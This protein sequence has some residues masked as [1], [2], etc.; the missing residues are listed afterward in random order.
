MK[1]NRYF[2][3]ILIST[4]FITLFVTSCGPSEVVSEPTETTIDRPDDKG[5]LATESPTPIVVP[6]ESPSPP[7]HTASGL[8]FSN[9]DGTWWI[10]RQ[11]EVQQLI[12]KDRGVLSP[13]GKWIAYI[14]EDP[15]TYMGDIWL[16]EVSSGARQNITIT[17]DRDEVSPLWVPGRPEFILFGSDTEIGMGNSAYPT[18]INVDGTGYQILDSDTGGLRDVSPSGEMFFYGG[19]DATMLAY[20]WDIGT[21]VFDPSD[22]GLSVNKLFIPEWSPDGNKVAWFV[23]GNFLDSESSQLAI[24]V[25][26]LESETAELMHVYEPIGGS[27]FV[28]N[29]AWSPNGEWLAFT[30]HSEPP[31]TGRAPNLWVIRPD[32]SDETYIGEGTVPVWRYD[33]ENL[34]FQALNEAQTE[35]VFLVVTG[36]WKVSMIDDLP[37]PERIGFLLDWVMP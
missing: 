10:D 17:P 24:A 27:E 3:I 37:L 13:D 11:G 22:F 25:F 34:A 33:G 7:A 16:M 21:E 31:A 28:N 8:V 18:V 23:A 19:Y 5:P 36:M 1:S 2:Y 9:A 12:D 29:L 14:E 15:A 6:T 35:E 30:T 4:L 26:D 32:G 20:W